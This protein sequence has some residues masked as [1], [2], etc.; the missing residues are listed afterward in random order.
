MSREWCS[1]ISNLSSIVN[2]IIFHNNVTLMS[3]FSV[4]KF[5]HVGKRYMVAV[6][7][8]VLD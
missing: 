1:A 8:D 7:E 3:K 4:C 5:I 2:N 6:V